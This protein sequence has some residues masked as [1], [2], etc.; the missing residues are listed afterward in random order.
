MIEI[1]AWTGII[2]VAVIIFL[3]DKLIMINKK[4]K[5]QAYTVE[6][7]LA[8][9]RR[10]ISE[11]EEWEKCVGFLI[12][13][14]TDEFLEALEA[15]HRRAEAENRFWE[16][17]RLN[18]IKEKYLEKIKNSAYENQEVFGEAAEK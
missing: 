2:L 11:L 13:E 9:M 16:T 14:K 6:T 7:Q 15:K 8:D 18:M 3:I 4:I 5:H 10:M 1:I 12:E 17:R